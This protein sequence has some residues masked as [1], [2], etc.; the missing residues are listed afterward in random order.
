MKC[1]FCGYANIQGEAECDKCGEDLTS[2]DGV[3]RPDRLE[4]SLTKDPISTLNTSDFARVT[5]DTPVKQVA[6]QLALSNRA[7]LVMEGET[8]VA[9]VTE[10]D[11]L[12][13][14]IGHHKS[15]EKTPVS[16]IMTRNPE[17]LHP[18]D[19][20]AVAL[21]KMSIGGFRHIPICDQGVPKGVL[22]ARDILSYLA[23]MFPQVVRESH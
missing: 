22:G 23:E 13:K 3:K 10:R 14:F 15:L 9:I 20:L 8:L 6:E 5:P 19:K 21:N 1:P 7:I 17:T 12:F 4:K 11:V 16:E 18:T 2:F